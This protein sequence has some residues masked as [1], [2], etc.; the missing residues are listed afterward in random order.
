MKKTFASLLVLVALFVPASAGV[1][2]T[3]PAPEPPPPV[4]ASTLVVAYVVPVVV[5]A[6]LP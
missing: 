4:P 3:G 6:A 1:M 5:T 2:E